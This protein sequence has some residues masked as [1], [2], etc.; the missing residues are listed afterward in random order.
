MSGYKSVWGHIAGLEG[1]RY[2][3]IDK[4]QGKACIFVLDA[5]DPTN[6]GTTTSNR[7]AFAFSSP[8]YPRGVGISLFFFF[9]SPLYYLSKLSYIYTSILLIT[10]I[11]NTNT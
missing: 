5:L 2:I 3:T 9:S 10:L 1:C 11:L 4:E 7:K 8:A 6:A